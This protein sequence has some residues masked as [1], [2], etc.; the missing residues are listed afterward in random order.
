MRRPT[1]IGLIWRWPPCSGP[2]RGRAAADGT[3]AGQYA[4]KGTFQDT[5]VGG[6]SG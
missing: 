4:E 5:T 2:D 6:L 1:L 3:P